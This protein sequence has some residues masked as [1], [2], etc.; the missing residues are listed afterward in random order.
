MDLRDLGVLVYALDL[1][2]HVDHRATDMDHLGAGLGVWQAQ[3]RRRTVLTIRPIRP[4]GSQSSY[5]PRRPDNAADDVHLFGVAFVGRIFR[6]HRPD[7][8][9]R[10][11]GGN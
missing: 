11:I 10:W 8:D 3:R 4:H 6:V 9:A 1:L 7:H 5:P 2:Q